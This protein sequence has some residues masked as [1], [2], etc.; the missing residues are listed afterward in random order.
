MIL[1]FVV[2]VGIKTSKLGDDNLENSTIQT[3][4]KDMVQST[5]YFDSKYRNSSLLIIGGSVIVIMITV[6]LT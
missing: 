5:F 6:R 4:R 2:E 1:L 3:Q